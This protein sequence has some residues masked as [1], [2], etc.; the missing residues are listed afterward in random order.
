MSEVFQAFQRSFLAQKR[1]PQF[2]NF[3]DYNVEKYLKLASDGF[4]LPLKKRDSEG[5]K[6]IIQKVASRDPD[7][8]TDFDSIRC[9]VLMSILL[10]LEEE[11]QICGVVVI[12]DY[13]DVTTKHLISSSTTI[14]VLKFLNYSSSFRTPGFYILNLP[15]IAK[16][17]IDFTM[18]LT[19]EKIKKRIN[20]LK[21]NE[22]LK[23][24][25][26]PI[27]LPREFGGICDLE[28]V[29]EDVYELYKN[30]QDVFLEF[31]NVKIDWSKVT[32]D[33]I[34]YDNETDLVGSFRK[35]EVD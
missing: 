15:S 18:S 21:E 35:L 24:F 10:M 6:V 20:V 1:F 3:D 33:D 26:D 23:E 31:A 14:E 2:C 5:R 7:I 27:L 29:V 16:F 4:F 25:I 11:T 9:N 12:V 8:Y 32:K 17:I 22:E 34:W 19:N 30:N 13:S 28:E